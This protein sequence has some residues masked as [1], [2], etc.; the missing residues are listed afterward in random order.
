M[1]TNKGSNSGGGSGSGGVGSA[2]G[3]S[4]MTRLL[5]G[6]MMLKYTNVVKGNGCDTFLV[7]SCIFY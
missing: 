5:N 3:S 2:S 7:L 4:N 6:Q 1:D